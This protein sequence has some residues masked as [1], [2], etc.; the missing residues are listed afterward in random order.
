MNKK[1]LIIALICIVLVITVGLAYYLNNNTTNNEKNNIVNTSKD[2]S[3]EIKFTKRG[4][5][6][7]NKIIDRSEMEQYDY[8]IYTYNGDVSIVIGEETYSFEDALRSNRITIDKIIEKVEEDVS[9]GIA[10][11]DMYQDGGSLIYKYDTF[12]I[13]K[14]KNLNGNRNFYIGDSQMLLDDIL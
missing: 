7:L 6:Q 5:K 4:D 12:R 10:Y 11:K 9:N 13:I 8:D 2:I 1:Y 14:C 3:F